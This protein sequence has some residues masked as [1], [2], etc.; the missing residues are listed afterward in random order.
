MRQL[1]NACRSTVSLASRTLGAGSAR[2]RI[3]TPVPIPWLASVVRNGK[4]SDIHPY[5]VVVHRVWE[6]T[7]DAEVNLIIILRPTIRVVV[8]AL[9]LVQCL[10][11]EGI[12][13]KRAAPKVPEEGFADLRFSLGKNLDLKAT[14]IAL[15][16]A[17]ASAQGTALTAPDRK[18]SRRRISSC[19]QASDTE[20]SAAPSRLSMSAATTAE[21]SSAGRPRASSRRWP[22][23]AFM[24]EQSST[25]YPWDQDGFMWARSGQRAARMPLKQDPSDDR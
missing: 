3:S 9:N 7:Q 20:P 18:A 21:R 4:Y 2:G 23:R 19:L 6:S 10:R 8:Q 11:A 25:R 22:T 14:H 13:G 1:G 17:R 16:R 12:C 5:Q 24:G 15:R